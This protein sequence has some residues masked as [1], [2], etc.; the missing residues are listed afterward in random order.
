MYRSKATGGNWLTLIRRTGRGIAIM[1][2]LALAMAS[3]AM[4]EEPESATTGPGAVFDSLDAAAIDALMFAHRTLRL[5]RAQGGAIFVTDGGF[6]YGPM[7]RATR[8]GFQLTLRT[9]DVG[10][11]YAD[12]YQRPTFGD[13]QPKFLTRESRSM[14]SEVDPY[15]RPL[16]LLSPGMKVVRFDGRSVD[17]VWPKRG[18]TRIEDVIAAN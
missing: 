1:G 2:V 4:A 12:N 9:G 16:Y 7:V 3:G 10:W 15:H 6:S 11:F 8:D 18:K 13:R 5:G 17:V 14:V